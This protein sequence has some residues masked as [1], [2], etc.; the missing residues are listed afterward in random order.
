MNTYRFV[1]KP[2]HRISAF[3]CEIVPPFVSLS[4]PAILASLVEDIFAAT[5]AFQIITGEEMMSGGR[6]L[7][8]ATTV[9]RSPIL[10]GLHRD[11]V[12][13]M[14]MHGVRFPSQS[15]VGPGFRPCIKVVHGE[16]FPQNSRARVLSAELQELGTNV[17][18][19]TVRRD[20]K[21]I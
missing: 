12:A 4:L 13:R 16:R 17:I 10:D 8:L 5:T 2:A 11:L 9:V 6:G 1:I 19:F 20:W 18:H 21:L 15:I 14:R 7:Q 3:E